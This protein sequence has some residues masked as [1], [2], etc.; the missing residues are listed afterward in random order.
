MKLS[1]LLI[2][3]ASTL[4]LGLVKAPARGLIID[5]FNDVDDDIEGLQ[6]IQDTMKDGAP[7]TDID[8]ATIPLTDVIG[9]IRLLEVN[10]LTGSSSKRSLL[11]VDATSNRLDFSSD[12]NSTG[13]FSLNWNGDF[14]GAG[15]N[16]FLDLTE[17]G[18]KKSFLVSVLT[19]D[20]GVNLNFE[21]SDGTNTAKLTQTLASGRTGN[22][23]FSFANF[24]NQTALAQAKSIKLYSSNAPAGLDFSLAL[25]E[26]SEEVPFEFSPSLGIV[27]SGSFFG[28]CAIRKRFKMAQTFRDNT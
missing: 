5:F 12:N 4:I 11:E 24:T 17:S 21:V 18:N 14:D 10:K 22:V 19:N 3:S 26:N 25:I 9:G 20:L 1:T 2:F 6:F 8:G 16:N 15:S 28:F 23:Y 13:S 27:L 7:V